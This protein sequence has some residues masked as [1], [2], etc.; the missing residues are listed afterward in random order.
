MKS[1]R[2]VF[3]PF[4]DKKYRFDAPQNLTSLHFSSLSTFYLRC[5]TISWRAAP[6]LTVLHPKQYV[7]SEIKL[8]TRF[9]AVLS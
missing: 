3:N 5:Q 9:D 1:S 2:Y 6:R 4:T 7:V 8:H